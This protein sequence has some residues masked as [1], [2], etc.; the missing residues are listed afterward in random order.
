MSSNRH[1]PPR[2]L[3]PQD[4]RWLAREKAKRGIIYTPWTE[5]PKEPAL[6]QCEGDGCTLMIVADGIKKYCHRCKYLMHEKKLRARDEGRRQ[7]R[8]EAA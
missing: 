7:K 4:W 2:P 6:R 3:T 5:A 1:N 8:R